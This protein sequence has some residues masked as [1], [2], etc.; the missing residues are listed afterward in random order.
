MARGDVDADS[1]VDLLV[2]LAPGSTGLALGGLLMDVQDL[3]QR[4]VDVVTEGCLH[5]ALRDRILKEAEPVQVQGERAAARRRSRS[6]PRRRRARGAGSATT[7]AIATR[8]VSSPNPS[9]TS[10]NATGPAMEA[11]LERV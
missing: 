7:T 9:L 1:D 10:P 3:L 6:G 4:R 5:P 11:A 8:A 2:S